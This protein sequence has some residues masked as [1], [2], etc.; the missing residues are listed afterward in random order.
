MVGGRHERHQALQPEVLALAPRLDDPVGV[1]Q[2]QV[3]PQRVLE[4]GERRSVDHPDE[5]SVGAD[6]DDRP[7]GVAHQRQGVTADAAGDRPL[8]AVVDEPDDHCR[9]EPVRVVGEHRAVELVEQVGRVPEQHGQG[10][11][12]V[13]HEGRDRGGGDALAGHVADH[14][15]PLVVGDLEHVVEVPSHLA[16]V[17]G[18]AVRRGD[19]QAVDGR[20]RRRDERALQGLGE[21]GGVASGGLDGPHRLEEVGLVATPVARLE[22]DEP[23]ARP[24]RAPAA[25]RRWR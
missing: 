18:R 2:Q 1:E 20:R 9:A 21:L 23:D 14:R 11:D 22:D 12:G 5:R 6:L 10:A 16:S 17:S 24:V 4:R 3:I 15:Q 7:V 13:P 8:P 25:G 19:G